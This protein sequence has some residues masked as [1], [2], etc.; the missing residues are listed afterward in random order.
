MT[1]SKTLSE[2]LVDNTQAIEKEFPAIAAAYERM[3][4]RF[5]SADAGKDALREGDTL[6]EFYLP[7]ETG[8]LVSSASLLAKGPLVVSMN[9][10]HFCGYCRYELDALQRI[11][12]DIQELNSTLVAITPE[13]Q[14]FAKQLKTERNLEFPILCDVDNAYALSLGLAV[15]FGE[16]IK[17]MY[18]ELGLDLAF[19]QGNPSWLVPIP[20]TY[21]VASDSRIVSSY[22]DADF[23]RRMEPEEVLA[24][25]RGLAS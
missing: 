24:T 16:E 18:A 21:V 1:S 20:A 12:R 8:R 22:V 2:A 13:R 25:L 17:P 10:G 15:W 11:H 5:L 6:P 3:V 14:R 9:R 19:F 23:R 4:H 7:D